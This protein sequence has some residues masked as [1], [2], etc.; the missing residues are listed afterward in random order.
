MTNEGLILIAESIILILFWFEGHE[1]GN[2]ARVLRNTVMVSTTVRRW[3]PQS[4]CYYRWQ[5]CPQARI[6]YGALG[7]ANCWSPFREDFLLDL[8]PRPDVAIMS[9][10][11]MK[12]G[13]KLP[14]YY[15]IIKMNCKWVCMHTQN[16]KKKFFQQTIIK[17]ELTE[18]WNFSMLGAKGNI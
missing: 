17:Y 12:S 2:W 4:E 10:Y 8:V 3:R 18:F 11:M 15:S 9:L 14:N 13:P 5:F 6:I 16:N 7:P 1:F